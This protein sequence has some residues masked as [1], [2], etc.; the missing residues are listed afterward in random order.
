MSGPPPE[1]LFSLLAI[2]GWKHNWSKLIWIAD[3]AAMLRH[4]DLN[5]QMIEDSA[6]RDG[7]RRIFLLALAM[8]RRV[9]GI[10]ASCDGAV[11]ADRD[12]QSLA[13]RLEAG[14]RLAR[15]N[16]YL[17]WHR[18]MLSARDSFADQ[19]GQV[20]HFVFTPGLAEYSAASLPRWASAGYR[21]IRIA[22]VLRLWPEKAAR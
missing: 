21:L 11:A 9:Y 12:I 18:D 6:A 5:W 4:F 1:G 3:L 22:R 8:V 19:V 17:E 14:L 16:S 20:A 13:E 15:N 10:E 2:H 7:W